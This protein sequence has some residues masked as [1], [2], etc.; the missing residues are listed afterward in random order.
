MDELTAASMVRINHNVKP[1]LPFKYF[2]IFLN[3]NHSS[4]DH[5]AYQRPKLST[6]RGAGLSRLNLEECS[7]CGCAIAFFPVLPPLCHP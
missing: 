6:R 3:D 5:K 4:F 1:F 2:S 7:L